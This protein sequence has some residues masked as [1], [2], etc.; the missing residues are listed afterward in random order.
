MAQQTVIV[1]GSRVIQVKAP[2]QGVTVTE[3]K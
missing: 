2:Q 1:K 3:K